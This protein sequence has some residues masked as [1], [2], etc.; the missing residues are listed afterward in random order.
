MKLYLLAIIPFIII[1]GSA[2][3]LPLITQPPSSQTDTPLSPTN[4]L[5]PTIIWF[6]P[7]P[8]YTPLPKVTLPVTPT[9]DFRPRYGDL[10]FSDDFN[11]PAMWELGTIQDGVIALGKD[12]LTLAVKKERGYL[13]S[14]RQDTILSDFY[15]EITAS[16]SICRDVDEYGF[17]LRV[18]NSSDFYRFSLTCDGQTRVDKFIKGHASSPQPLTMSGAIPPGAPSNSQLAVWAVGKEMRFFANGEHLFTVYEPTLPSGGIGV[19]ARASG[20]DDVTVSYSNLVV[21][22]ATE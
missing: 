1:A 10:I 2:A 16:P 11:D 15:A 20:E 14:L 9:V 13:F 19:F 22:E 17:L 12:E 6:P 4:T 5:T 8:T 21:Y 18:S 3:C 7:T